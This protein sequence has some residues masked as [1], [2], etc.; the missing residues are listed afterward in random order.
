MIYFCNIIQKILSSIGLFRLSIAKIIVNSIMINIV[1]LNF[2]LYIHIQLIP[3]STCA[4][5]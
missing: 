2:P 3:T 1:N 4:K 5:L